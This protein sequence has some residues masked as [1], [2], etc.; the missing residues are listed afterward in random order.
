[1]GAEPGEH[2]FEALAI[3]LADGE[4]T[5]AQAS[6]TFYVADDGVGLDAAFLNEEVEL[7]GHAFFDLEVSGLDEKTLNADVEDA[8]DIVAAIATPADPNVFR[9]WKAS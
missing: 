2:S 5:K 7:G 6:A 3:F 4:E 9:S 8:R 1:M